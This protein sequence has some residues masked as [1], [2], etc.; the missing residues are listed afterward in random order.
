LRSGANYLV[1][2]RQVTRA[3]DPKGEAEK[4]LREIQAEALKA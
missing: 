4:I 2:G 1:I 3:A